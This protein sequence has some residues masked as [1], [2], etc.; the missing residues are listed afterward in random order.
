[1]IVCRCMHLCKEMI[2]VPLQPFV[3]RGIAIYYQSGEDNHVLLSPYIRHFFLCPLLFFSEQHQLE[4]ADCMVKILC[5]T[6][7]S[8]FYSRGCRMHL[9]THWQLQLFSCG[10][11]HLCY[12]V[13]QCS[14][15]LNYT[16]TV[17]GVVGGCCRLSKYI[18]TES[19]SADGQVQK[20]MSV[21]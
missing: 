21:F 4:T 1:M 20:R 3:P 15:G 14:V 10:K 17:K 7:Y 5:S 9:V 18:L 11:V 6:C 2:C 19:C 16:W 13:K 12:P 8:D